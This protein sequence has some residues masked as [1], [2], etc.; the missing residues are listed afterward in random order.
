MKRRNFL[1]TGSA[2]T[3]PV[4]VNGFSLGFLPKSAFFNTIDDESDRVLVLIQLDGGNDGLATLLPTD[5]Y[6][7]LF[8]HRAGIIVPEAS[9]LPLHDHV[10]LHPGMTG[11][12]DLFDEGK[13]TAIQAV[14][15]PDQNRSHFRSTDIWQS[16][17]SA[18]EFVTSGWMGRYFDANFPGFPD[19]YPNEDYPDPFAITVQYT[20]SN[21]CQGNTSNYS[22]ALTDPF[23]LGQIDEAT[24]DEL[25]DTNF[26]NEMAFLINAIAQ[27]NAYSDTV[28]AAANAGSNLSTL[29]DDSSDLAQQ[30]K[31]VALLISGGLKTKVFVVRIGGFDLHA[32]QVV[33]GASTTG[34]HAELLTNLANAVAAFQDDLQ[35]QGLEERVLG[36]TFSEFGRQI[37]SNDSFGTDHGTGAPLFL[38]GSCVAGG[39]IGSNPEIG[40][41]IEPQAG[42]EMQFDY[43]SVYATILKDWFGAPEQ[44]VQDLLFGDFDALPIIEGCIPTSTEGPG[45]EDKPYEM[46]VYPNPTSGDGTIDFHSTGGRVQIAIY[47]Q[48]GRQI[49]V[50]VDRDYSKGRHNVPFSTY[51]LPNGSYIIR[52]RGD[53]TQEV[54]RLV[55]L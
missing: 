51:N 20:V 52:L 1:R 27:T 11:F 16:G 6:D 4:L 7:N 54:S 22:M 14:A 47:D 13:L 3:L 42:V 2:I 46:N 44:Q 9:I 32:N 36:M 29:Y 43:R 41:D 5:Q 34:N 28:L 18:E 38:F 21:T 40:Q 49:G 23:S 50:I 55:K 12:R 19:D 24:I 35:K 17:S 53:G 26:G 48:M 31:T 39:V 45:F 25:P 8:S 33:Q 30:L 15:Y 10:G 37:K